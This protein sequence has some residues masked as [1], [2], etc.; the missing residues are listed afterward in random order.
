MTHFVPI[1]PGPN[2]QVPR[3]KELSLFD[4]NG[5]ASISVWG[6]PANATVEAEN[7]PRFVAA[8][9]RT[10]GDLTSFYL[11]GLVAGDRIAVQLADGRF[12]T[13]WLPIKF[14]AG[15]KHAKE[16]KDG[17]LPRSRHMS[18]VIL[19]AH[20]SE[21][22]HPPVSEHDWLAG[23]ES[24]LGK[25]RANPVGRMI[26]SSIVR[27]ITI[28]PFI[29]SEINANSSILF[30]AQI[31]A[32]NNAPGARPDEVLFHELCHVL[33]RNFDGYFDFPADTLEFDDS[34]FFTVMATNVYA[35]VAGRPLRADHHEFNPMIALYRDPA[36]G[37]AQLKTNHTVNFRSI[38]TRMPAVARA[39]SGA[40]AVWNPFR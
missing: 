3:L 20:G 5:T 31:F 27:D 22:R 10:S 16:R 21:Q 29:P 37:V 7:N 19:D 18:N 23:V 11:R 15:D 28:H 8:P 9:Y 25:I 33:E 39:L 4:K 30:T 2:Y 38:K 36:T 24:A 14:A 1:P 26:T 17:T 13:A 35:S 12:W 34:D 32:G 6:M 40:P